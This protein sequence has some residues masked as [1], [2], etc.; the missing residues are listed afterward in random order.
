MNHR[1]HQGPYGEFARMIAYKAMLAGLTVERVDEAYTSQECPECGH[2]Q[3]PS[4]RGYTCSECGFHG[5]RDGVGAANI[6]R[7]YVATKTFGGPK[8]VRDRP[9]GGMASPLGSEGSCSSL[10]SLAEQAYDQRTDKSRAACVEREDSPRLPGGEVSP[11][12]CSSTPP[13]SASP[14]CRAVS[15]FRNPLVH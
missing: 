6:R 8:R 12:S 3:K 9:A 11:H 7:R 2:R 15:P 13:L 10:V 1:L 4:G 5:H 14:S